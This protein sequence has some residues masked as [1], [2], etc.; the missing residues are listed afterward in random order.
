MFAEASWF[1]KYR[2]S[3]SQGTTT[4]LSK[5]RKVSLSYQDIKSKLNRK[6][7][8]VA[9]HRVCCLYFSTVC[10]GVVGGG[11]W[12]VNAARNEPRASP[13]TNVLWWD[14]YKAL[15]KGMLPKQ[16]IITKGELQQK[17]WGDEGCVWWRGWGLH[18]SSWSHMEGGSL[19]ASKCFQR[20][21]VGV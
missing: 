15:G 17:S 16:C 14:Y 4:Q 7:Y 3:T 19:N 2:H 12:R 20:G 11:C 13:I 18:P 8:T 10:V 9:R 6:K 21:E 1:D 5:V